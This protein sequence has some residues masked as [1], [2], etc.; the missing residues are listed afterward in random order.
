MLFQNMKF[1]MYVVI[2]KNKKNFKNIVLFRLEII[3]LK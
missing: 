1:K 3:F 2:Q